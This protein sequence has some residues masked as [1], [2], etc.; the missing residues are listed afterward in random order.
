MLDGQFEDYCVA[1][2]QASEYDLLGA[3]N[4]ACSNGAN[5]TAIQENQPCYLPNTPKDHASYAFNSYYQN[6]KHQGG[7]CYFTATAVLTGADPSKKPQEIL[8]IHVCKIARSF[9]GI[10]NSKL[11]LVKFL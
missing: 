4:W 9:K 11:D 1:D 10:N 5:C 3:M 6:M 2:E 8:S 7:G